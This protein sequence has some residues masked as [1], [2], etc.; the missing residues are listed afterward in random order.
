MTHYTKIN[1]G[2][3]RTEIIEILRDNFDYEFAN[4]TT[5]D[6]DS[7]HVILPGAIDAL[8]NKF[9]EMEEIIERLN[10]DIMDLQYSLDESGGE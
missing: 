9:K 7:V 5:L 4:I 1:N 10:E 2:L 3:T 6:K 8:E